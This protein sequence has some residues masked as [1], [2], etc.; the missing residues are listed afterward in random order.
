MSSTTHVTSQ[1]FEAV[2]EH[3]GLGGFD[4]IWMA[5]IEWVEQPN[6]RRGGWSGVGRLELETPTGQIMAVYVKRQADHVARSVRHPVRGELTAVREQANI[7]LARRAGI[8]TQD[9]LYCAERTHVGSRQGILITKELQAVPLDDWWETEE[10]TPSLRRLVVEEAAQV[11]AALH[12]ARLQHNALYPKHIFV[13][14]ADDDVQVSLIDLE[15]ARR[16]FTKRSATLR[17]LDSLKR[18]SAGSL[19]DRMRFLVAYLGRGATDEER[20]G[21]WRE[22]SRLARRKQR[23]RVSP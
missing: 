21:L 14:C 5:S 2:L 11:V 10:S 16:R 12:Q 8:P 13:H 20:R 1:L 22:L 15:K 6:V 17:D 4:A 18:R 7:A 19:A 9:V 23:K 3:N